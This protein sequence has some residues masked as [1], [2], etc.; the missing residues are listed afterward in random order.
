MAAQRNKGKSPES[1]RRICGKIK[2]LSEGNGKDS[3]QKHASDIDATTVGLTDQM[4]S[5]MLNAYSQIYS[6]SDSSSYQSN[7]SSQSSQM[8]TTFGLLE[9]ESYDEKVARIMREKGVDK[10]VAEA[11]V[12]KLVA[13]E[14][15]ALQRQEF[16]LKDKLAELEAQEELASQNQGQQNTTTES[17]AEEN[18]SNNE[19]TNTS[20]DNSTATN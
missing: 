10:E 2:Q 1:A 11:V 7:P 14:A 6:N 13:E 3:K 19:T 8:A 16:E 18:Q 17:T 5:S 20:T 15:I 9:D 12:D 4:R